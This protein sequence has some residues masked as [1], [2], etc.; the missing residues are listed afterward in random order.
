MSDLGRPLEAR[1]FL[2]LSAADLQLLL[3]VGREPLHGYGMMK[4]VVEDS[5]GSLRVELGSL[6][7]MIQRLERE[8]L[9]EESEPL[10]EAPAPGRDR[11]FYRITRLGADVVA[12]ELER[13]RGVLELVEARQ[14]RPRGAS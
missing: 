5:G 14:M 4:A 10:D 12:A 11:R 13:L 3:A 2:P 7:R 9:I 8:G 1:Q 6:Y